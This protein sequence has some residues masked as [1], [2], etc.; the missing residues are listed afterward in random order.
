MGSRFL[1]DAET[2]RYAPIEGEAL[3]VAY[4]LHQCRYFVL[5]CPDLVIATDHKPLTSVLNERSLSD[6]QNR[7]LQNLKEKNLS[8]RF[9][10]V[11]VPG[12]KQLGEDATSRYPVGDPVRLV[13]PGEPPETD[14]AST[15]ELRAVITD[16]L[17]I[18]DSQD[19][20]L[21]CEMVSTSCACLEEMKETVHEC[22][23]DT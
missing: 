20:S 1:H 7:R 15:A 16:N 3:A 4:A 9:T 18:M 5:G 13:L 23:T 22:C 6:I 21:E 17:A 11:D 10:I 14:F 8:Y 12:R 2:S 19:T